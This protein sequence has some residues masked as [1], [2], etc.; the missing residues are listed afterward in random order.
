[1]LTEIDLIG[2]RAAEKRGK[3]WALTN[4]MRNAWNS[5]KEEMD[6]RVKRD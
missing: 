5:T 2:Q 4:F 1:V 3:C 6:V